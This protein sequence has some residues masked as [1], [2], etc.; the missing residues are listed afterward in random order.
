MVPPTRICGQC[1]HK[2]KLRS[3]PDELRTILSIAADANK[4]LTAAD[5]LKGD[6]RLD[7]KG[8]NSTEAAP[9]PFLHP[10]KS[11]ALIKYVPP[12][13]LHLLL[14]ITKTLFHYLEQ[15]DMLLAND[16]LDS[17]NVRRSERHGGT[18]FVGNDCRTILRST[19]KLRSLHRFPSRISQR[20]EPKEFH[21]L[22]SIVLITN[23][24]QSFDVVISRT[25]GLLL[26][27]EWAT[28]ITSFKRDYTTFTQCF[29]KVKSPQSGRDPSRISPKLQCYFYEVPVWINVHRCSLNRI[30][31]QAFE[32]LH[33]VYLRFEAN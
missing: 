31:E 17:I 7:P 24:L 28:S 21:R 10:F 19:S 20:Q 12:P 18:D 11:L 26:H 4:Y 9:I 3:K 5:E 23:V 14:G 13:P 8:F 29:N 27:P 33:K 16:F 25:T 22:T 6:D 32:T 30:T 2:S 15:L 1:S